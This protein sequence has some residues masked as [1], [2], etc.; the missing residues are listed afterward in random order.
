MADRQSVQKIKNKIIVI[1]FITALLVVAMIIFF[2]Y[3]LFG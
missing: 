1:K 2:A 3:L